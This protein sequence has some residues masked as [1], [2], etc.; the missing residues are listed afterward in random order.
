[1][2]HIIGLGP[3][4]PESLS[5][6]AF[7]LVCSGLPVLMRAARHPAARTEPIHQALARVPVTALDDAPDAAVVERVLAAWAEQGEIVY[8]VPGH[9]LVDDPT[10]ARL[11][12]L[13]GERRIPFEIAP[14][15]WAPALPAE[16]RGSDFS[17]LVGIMARLRAP[18]GCPWDREQ[19]HETLRKYVI[20]EA[21]EVVEAIDGGDADKLCEELGDL[22]LQVVF[23]AQLAA[24]AGAFTID[25]VCAA[26]ADK[27]VR[28]HPHVFGDVKVRGSDDVLTNWQAI[29]AGEPGNAERTSVLDGIPRSL[30]ALMRAFEVSRRAVKVGFEWPDT[31]SVLDKVD[32]ELAELRVEIDAARPERIADEL[33]DLLFTIVNVARRVGIEPEDALGRQLEKFGRRFRHIEARARHAGVPVDALTLDQME[34]FWQEAKTGESENNNQ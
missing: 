10:V 27:L 21:Y 31:A 16:R 17:E 32:E 30:P 28:R 6:R 22:L 4:D 25:D 3:G 13:L 19:T 15:T 5:P 8:A 9:P 1:M 18:E 2:I 11:L 14:A 26:I 20:E 34:A 23:H 7:A 29:K 33:G 12:P 24:E